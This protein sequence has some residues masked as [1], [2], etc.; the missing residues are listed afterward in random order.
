MCRVVKLSISSLTQLGSLRPE[1]AD[2]AARVLPDLQPL[3]QR[4]S[5]LQAVE[6]P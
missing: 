4:P 5:I 2:H 6:G 1:L 3:V